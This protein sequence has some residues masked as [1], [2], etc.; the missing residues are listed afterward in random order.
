MIKDHVSEALSL[1]YSGFHC[2][3]SVFAAFSGD[4][5][6]PR[7]TALKISCPFG[8][9]MGGYGKTCGALTGAM[10]VMGLKYGS[11]TPDD[12]IAKVKSREKTRN[13][14]EYFEK[15]HGSSLC[16]DL[17][18]F[19]RTHVTGPELLARMPQIHETCKKYLE[20][21]ITYLE[22]EC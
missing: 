14:I 19:D 5:G 20:S 7:E 1:F 11:S 16:N 15:A 8:G 10:M 2:S 13:L 22:K 6:L 17:I 4:F 18:G 9:G 21:V 3:Q 12:F